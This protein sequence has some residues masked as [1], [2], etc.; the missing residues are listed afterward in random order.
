MGKP[1]KLMW[2]RADDARVGR[3]HPMAT[4]KVR[5]TFAG[6]Q[7][8]AFQQSHT[9]VETD[10]R[11][12]LGEMLTATGAD[13]PAGLG[14][15]GFA[16]GIFAMTTVL[17]YDFAVKSQQL[18]E[19]DDRFNTGS[20]RNIYSPDVR[21]AAELVIDRIAA[22]SGLDPYEFRRRHLSDE[23]A[24]GVLEA[25]AQAGRWG[26]TMRPGTAQGIAVHVEYKGATACLVEIDCR[27]KTVRRDIAD[28][29]GGPR[30]TRVTFAVDAGLPINPRGLE[31]QMHGGIND[32]IAQAL[33]SSMHLRDGHFLEA[34]WD[35]YFYTR[36]WNTPPEVRVIVMPPTTGV[37]GGAGEA[38]VAASMAAVACAYA[39]ATG[40]TPTSFP[41]NH[42][43]PLRFKVKPY[44]P[45]VP[46]SPVNGLKK[47]Y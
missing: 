26:R 27:R 30:V 39:R 17:P 5:A 12:G 21:T 41:I 24:L 4:S 22:A 29:V 7:L 2:H 44:V 6:D 33:T 8:L 15:L 25:V 14:N 46:P 38:G 28:G 45:P 3:V 1:V 35:N 16:E 31:A 36:Q 47:T 32:G 40:R 11:H 19:T 23:R 20:M 10:Y 13:L 18:A 43:D 34:S 37:P 42:H 9:S